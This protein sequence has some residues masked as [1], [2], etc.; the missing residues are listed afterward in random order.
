MSQNNLIFF[1]WKDVPV[2][3]NSLYAPVITDT[4]TERHLPYT[5][6][7][8][9]L[10][11]ASSLFWKR[12]PLYWPNYVTPS[13]YPSLYTIDLR[14]CII[15]VFRHPSSPCA[16]TTL[17]HWLTRPNTLILL[18]NHFPIS[19]FLIRS[20]TFTHRALLKP[21]VSKT[22]SVLL[23][24]SF[25]THISEP[26]NTTKDALLKHSNFGSN[27]QTSVFPQTNQTAQ[28]PCPFTQPM[29]YL[30]FQSPLAQTVESNFSLFLNSLYIN[31]LCS[32][33]PPSSHLSSMFLPRTILQELEH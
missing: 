17:E 21:F 3:S 2:I 25:S 20:T 4:F 30:N 19:L 28:H 18:P 33:P 26:Y 27:E 1:V 12:K 23:S 7:L 16:Q 13:V 10:I 29:A 9:P 32:S 31:S 5:K 14:L 6:C 15:Y 8:S 24:L 22:S 11:P